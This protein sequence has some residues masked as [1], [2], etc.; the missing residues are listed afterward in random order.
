MLGARFQHWSKGLLSTLIHPGE[1]KAKGILGMN[2]RNV[3]FIGRYNDRQLYPSVD[4]K[5]KTKQLAETYQI[6][7]PKMHGVI[8]E[9]HQ[10]SHLD[11]MIEHTPGF[12]IKP[13]RGSGGKGILIIQD[14]QNGQFIRSSGKRI[15]YEGLERH[16]SNILA[17]LHSL[18]GMPDVAIIEDLVQIDPMFADVSYQGVPDIRIIVFKGY[19]VMAMLRLSTRS[20]DG[21]ANLHQGAIGVGLDIG[22]GQAVYAVQFERRLTQH[23]DTHASLEA[24][25][26]PDWP[27]L[28]SLASGCYD[29]TGLGYLGVDIVLDRNQGPVLL[30]L[31]ARPGLSIQLANGQGLLPRLRHLEALGESTHSTAAERVAY[32]QRQFASL[33]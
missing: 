23:P 3:D 21:K 19:P 1:L 15:A 20:S 22:S 5:L 14:T 8:R 28:L 2:A 7:T 4:N 29:M 26:I 13:A 10:V 32:A 33:S 30:E 16:V 25:Q 18:G 12:A 31:N 24:I 17:G 9:Q 27:Q 11:R 6:S